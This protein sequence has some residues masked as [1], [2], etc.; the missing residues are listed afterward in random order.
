M[1]AIPPALL[2]ELDL[3]ANAPVGLTVKSGRLVV[4]PKGRKRYSLDE[5][6]AQCNPKAR[7]TREEKE[8]VSG[9]RAGRELI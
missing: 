4:E 2:E 8:W 6:L 3:A 7:R 9:G 1:L 5:L